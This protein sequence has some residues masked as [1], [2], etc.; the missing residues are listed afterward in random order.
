MKRT[1][2]DVQEMKKRRDWIHQINPCHCHCCQVKNEVLSPMR[3]ASGP[4][5]SWGLY[6]SELATDQRHLEPQKET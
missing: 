5:F 4:F 1:R 6:S 2:R 3:S